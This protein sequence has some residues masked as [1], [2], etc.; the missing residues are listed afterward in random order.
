MN[1]QTEQD[2]IYTRLYSGALNGL[3]QIAHR[4]SIADDNT[5]TEEILLLLEKLGKATQSLKAV[6]LILTEGEEIKVM[7][8][9]KI[10]EFERARNIIK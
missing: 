7:G 6:E 5:P 4:L 3:E 8:G 2:N 1:N 10:G 9:V